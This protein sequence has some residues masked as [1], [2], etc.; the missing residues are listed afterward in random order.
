[1]N[2]MNDGFQTEANEG[3][4]VVDVDSIEA[5]KFELLPKGWYAA[6]I[7]QH[8]YVL[9][10]SSGQPMWTLQLELNVPGADKPRKMYY[11]MSW[12]PGAAPYTKTLTEKVFADVLVNPNYRTASNKL[13]I[14]K[15]GDE[16]AFVG[17]DV[18]VNVQTQKYEGELR[19][20]AKTLRLPTGAGLASGGG[21]A[22]LG[23]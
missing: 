21:N 2:Q 16:A 8:D 6:Q 11:H 19:N 22:F 4:H 17:R 1:M 20:Q 5:A 10:Q 9:S 15:I 23:A 18:E 12:A 7:V 3:T 14:K 13:D